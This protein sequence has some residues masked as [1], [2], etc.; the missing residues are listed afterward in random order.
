MC[1]LLLW[2]YAFTN[3]LLWLPVVYYYYVASP[4]YYLVFYTQLL[5]YISVCQNADEQTEFY[6]S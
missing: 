2:L 4:Q 1:T 5:Y 3:S 6:S